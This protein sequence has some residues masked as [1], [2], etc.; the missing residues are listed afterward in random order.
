MNRGYLVSVITIFS[1]LL[2]SSCANNKQMSNTTGWNYNDRKEGSFY[3]RS[4]KDQ[5]LAPGLV[6][7]QG[8]S[9]TMGQTQ[10]DVMHF[11]NN[12]PR[13]ITVNSFMIDKYEIS[14]LNYREYTHWVGNVFGTADMGNVVTASMPDTTCWRRAL[15]YNEPMVQLYFSHPAYN[16]YPVVGVTW[17]QA[18]DY[19]IWRTDRVNE[20]ALINAGYQKSNVI[21]QEMNGGGQNNFNTQSYL[22][23]LYQGLPSKPK[24]NPIYNAQGRVQTT[25]SFSD[26][27]LFPDYRLPTEAEWEYAALGLVSQ[28][29]QP[30]NG[31]MKGRGEEL[32]ANKNIY[33][34]KDDGYDN[35]R[36]TAKGPWQGAFLANFKRGNGDYMGVI[37]G[38]NDNA[39]FP[40]PVNAYFPNSF[41]L[42]NMS[43]N[44]S[45]WVFDV[46]RQLNSLEVNDLNPVRGN[47]FTTPDTSSG[48][49]ELTDV[50]R[51]KMATINDST[52]RNNL[53]YQHGYEINAKDGDEQSE[54]YYSY[55]TTTLI[56]D[57]ARVIKGGSWDDLPYWL[58][59]GAR[60]FLNEDQ[61][62]ATVGFRCAMSKY[63]AVDGL[64]K[65]SLDGNY[66]PQR[67]QK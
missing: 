39:A 31:T 27:I 43:G 66:F 36:G 47:I 18:H 17:R 3:V 49:L 40:S 21:K 28:N 15:A 38:L 50:G 34:W 7:I 59:P 52:L 16:N 42:Y 62:S 14:N 13:K 19:A 58:S 51:V 48:Q 54:A 29:P 44:V 12:I 35:L 6:F 11:W 64:N 10:E 56:S 33:A 2:L 45:E 22:M 30:G 63:G 32:L 8:G 25:V 41:G 55:G 23:G 24:D 37:G 20:K 57:K 46:Y 67:R 4:A 60:R 9:F 61:S 5:R 65:G 1:V 53:N 26:G